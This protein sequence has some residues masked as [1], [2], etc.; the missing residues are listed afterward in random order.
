VHVV[1]GPIL[2][3]EDRAHEPIGHYPLL[4]ASLATQFQELGV[5]VVAVTAHGWAL[6]GDP[7]FA[8]FPLVRFGR[9]ALGLSAFATWINGRTRGR[10]ALFLRDLC[11][12]TAIVMT[13][14]RASRRVGATGVVLV[15]RNVHPVFVALFADR[16]PW[17]VFRFDQPSGWMQSSVA[18]PILRLA[19]LVN[20]RRVRAGGRVRLLL[21]NRSALERWQS[22]TPWLEPEQILFT[23]ARL[24]PIEGARARLGLAAS[25]R[26]ALSFGAA[27]GGKDLTTVF[28]AFAD[29]E[30]WRL[31]IAGAGS[32]EA[33]VGWAAAHGPTAREPIVFDGYVDM[34]TRT[35]LFSAAD[36]VVLS[37]REV[38]NQD[39]GTFVDAI[40][41]GAAVVYS[42]GPDAAVVR[43]FRLGEV[44]TPGD[45]DSL[46]SAMRSVRRPEPADVADAQTATSPKRSAELVLQ[47][48][49]GG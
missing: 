17:V 6:E 23:F 27:H 42:D 15:S 47:T 19:R 40:S 28:E 22:L 4:F 11:R 8:P 7:A 13:A 5:D 38:H 30:G 26:L 36:A 29:L 16:R 25:D 1:I 41:A 44:F 18:R 14:R 32:P 24:T 46:R 43:E 39:S 12:S 20:D 48:L 45:V 2:V 33:Y 49:M 35:S 10:T 37:F 9:F 31:V 3:V 34:E 21:N